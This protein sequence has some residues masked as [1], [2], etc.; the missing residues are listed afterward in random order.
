MVFNEDKKEGVRERERER[1]VERSPFYSVPR[2]SIFVSV[3]QKRLH[4][5]LP[6]TGKTEGQGRGGRALFLGLVVQAPRLDQGE[7]NE[8]EWNE[9][10]IVKE[11]P[12]A[13]LEWAGAPEQ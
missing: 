5:I 7:R 1:E 13:Y 3:A 2:Y 11:T 6:C 12:V 8:G 10:G 4:L 9:R